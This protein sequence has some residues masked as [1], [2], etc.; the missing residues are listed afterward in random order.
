[1]GASVGWVGLAEVAVFSIDPVRRDICCMSDE[2]S[3]ALEVNGL[4]LS[5]TLRVL[6]HM[7]DM[8]RSHS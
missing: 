1:M 6:K 4:T 7:L 8:C 5:M 2:H 3:V